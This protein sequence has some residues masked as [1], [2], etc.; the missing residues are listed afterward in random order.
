[1]IAV[2]HK[3]M[4]KCQTTV[5]NSSFTP[6]FVDAPVYPKTGSEVLRELKRSLDGAERP[7]DRKF[8]QKE[9]ARLLG[10]PKSTIHDWCNG[11]LPRP[12]M[13]FLSGMERL[14]ASQ[15]LE[16]LRKLCR[17]NLS[18]DD[19]R[20]S[21]DP[22]TLSAVKALLSRPQGLT[23][24]TAETEKLS[25]LL[26][27]AMG[28]TAARY[29]H[30]RAIVGL[31]VYYPDRFV[32]VPGVRYWPT[33]GRNPEAHVLMK[34]WTLVENS[35]ARLVFLNGVL[36]MLPSLSERIVALARLK[37]VVV[38]DQAIPQKLQSIERSLLVVSASSQRAIRVCLGFSG[39]RQ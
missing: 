19:L 26:L 11:E 21:H 31:D 28:N 30:L 18:L 5:A 25:T 6:T 34:E 37:H 1:V 23:V 14:S 27:R 7:S 2:K 16:L 15:R 32:P 17:E 8:D 33:K 20:F 12:I 38:A 4:K 22:K 13:Y 3:G 9:F 29:L 36:S 10:A 24:V 39:A 35:P